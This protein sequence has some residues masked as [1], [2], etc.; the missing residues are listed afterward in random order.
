MQSI[1]DGFVTKLE[2]TWEAQNS[3]KSRYRK[4]TFED[5][6]IENKNI[7]DFTLGEKEH[8][9]WCSICWIL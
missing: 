2:N 7:A 9:S 3:A 5:K 8:W 1:A 6:V 4:W